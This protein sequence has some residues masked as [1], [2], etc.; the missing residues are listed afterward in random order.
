MIDTAAWR[1][2]GRF[3]GKVDRRYSCPQ[4]ERGGIFGRPEMF[5]GFPVI[6]I[7][8]RRVVLMVPV[9]AYLSDRL[10]PPETG[11]FRRPSSSQH[12]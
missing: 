11:Y 7:G 8:A 2:S 5:C 4:S 12:A 9:I 6:K 1:H 10:C 3:S